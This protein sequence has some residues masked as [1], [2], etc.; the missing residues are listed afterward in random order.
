MA[1]PLL[2]GVAPPVPLCIAPPIPASP[3]PPRLV[4]P[5]QPNVATNSHALIVPLFHVIFDK[6]IMIPSYSV[7]SASCCNL[8]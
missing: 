6:F 1:P 4:P 3:A 2:L 8:S 7:A 5:L